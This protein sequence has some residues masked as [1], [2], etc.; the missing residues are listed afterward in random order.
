M[1]FISLALIS[2][3]YLIPFS[4]SAEIR[5]GGLEA[6]FF[7]GYWE[8][9]R[10]VASA[11]LYG[12][13]VGYHQSRLLSFE[14]SLSQIST[15][16]KRFSELNALE[17]S[18]EEASFQQ[19]GFATLFHLGAEKISPYAFFG[20]GQ[21]FSESD[22][23]LAFQGGLGAHYFISDDLSARLDLGVW[24]AAADGGEPYEHFNLSFGLSYHIGGERDIDGDQIPNTLDRCPT[25]KEDA[26]SFQDTDGC[27]DEDNDGDKIPD[28]D[29]QCPDQKE[30]V[31]EDRD[32]D[33]CPDID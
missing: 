6:G 29:D 18:V 21:V 31:D 11:S 3:A 15:E 24:R 20:A 25:M 2:L 17:S 33:G 30:D 8:G 10:S 32:E 12:G 28:V 26:D 22:P 1:R 19:L 5:P 27:P 16:A 13:R 4:A 14:L 23:R 9:N 7:G